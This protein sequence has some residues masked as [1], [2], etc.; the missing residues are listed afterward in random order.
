MEELQNEELEQAPSPIQHA[1]KFGAIVGMVSAIFTLLLY[2][3]DPPL[4]T[5]MWLGFGLL[6]VFL[7]LVIYG[8]ITFRKEIG[9][10]IDFGPAYLHG[11]IVL[12]TM[13]VISLV[14]NLLLHNVVDPTLKDTLTEAAIEQSVQLMEKF[15][16]PQD[17][18]DEA[19]EQQ[20]EGMEA[21][22]TTIGQLKGAMWAIVGYAVI[23]LITGLVVRRRE[24][25]S[26]VV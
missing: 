13:G 2:V 3:I 15:G 12:V 26:D 16:A 4:L 10:Y 18:I 9:G 20:R 5:N 21:Q 19:I 6:A 17:A 23:A 8:G 14:V 11:F 24:Q 1:V 25:V 22:F 7:G